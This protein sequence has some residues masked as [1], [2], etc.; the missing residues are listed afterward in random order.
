MVYVEQNPLRA[1]LVRR[2][3]DWK[4]SSLYRRERGT[5]AKLLAELPIE[6]PIDYLRVVNTL[7]GDETL[8]SM[9]QSV[10][11]GT[12]FG[13]T[14]WVDEMVQRFKLENT[15]RKPGRPKKG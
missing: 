13:S 11:R 7:P 4:W 3:E 8:E 9:R 6:L 10:N 15:I 5:D 1:K 14:L 2:A 12:P